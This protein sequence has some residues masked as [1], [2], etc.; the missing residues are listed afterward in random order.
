M[1][2]TAGA[3]H[4]AVWLAGWHKQCM[5]THWQGPRS[6]GPRAPCLLPPEEGSEPPGRGL[7]PGGARQQGQRG[8]PARPAEAEEAGSP[9]PAAV[10]GPPVRRRGGQP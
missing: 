9:L 7:A 10:A 8:R 3:W 2:E 5:R 1:K 4:L 6:P